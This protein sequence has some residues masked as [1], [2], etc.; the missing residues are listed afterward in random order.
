[1]PT[2]PRAPSAQEVAELARDFE[3]ELS[4]AEA[5]S[6]A[7]MISGAV[8]AYR[9]I[10]ELPERKPPV[11]Y[12]RTPGY[13]PG[14]DENPYNAWYWKT[15]IS[16]AAEGP[17]KGERV[18]VKDAI[19]VAGVPMMNGSA[20]M[21]GFVPDIDATVVTRLL[22]AGATVVGKTNTEDCSLSGLATP[23]RW[24]R[25]AIRTSRLTDPAVHRREAPPRSPPAMSTWRSGAIRGDRS[26]VRRRGPAS[27]ASSRPMAW[28]R[29]PAAR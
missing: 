4:A 14:P 27:M 29:I 16:G 18:E 10:E 21:E 12:P 15:E 2:G 13:R 26:A 17:L 3:I 8:H 5:E 20:L 1:M 7:T 19:C 22:D 23:A 28:C 11:K 6:Y 9:R 24:G 25:C